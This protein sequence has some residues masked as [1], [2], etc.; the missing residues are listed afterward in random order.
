M[1]LYSPAWGPRLLGGCS[2]LGEYS[3]VCWLSCLFS[4]AVAP[5]SVTEFP[6]YSQLLVMRKKCRKQVQLA[7]HEEGGNRQE[8]LIKSERR[9]LQ[10]EQERKRQKKQWRGIR[11]SWRWVENSSKPLSF[12]G[13]A[14]LWSHHWTYL[15]RVTN[16]CHSANCMFLSLLLQLL[17][18]LLF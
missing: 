17:P 13:W 18:N 14:V 12:R 15:C 9:R 2:Y 1:T 10:K 11:I 8:R 4:S 5:V 3:S 16:S 6:C 7:G